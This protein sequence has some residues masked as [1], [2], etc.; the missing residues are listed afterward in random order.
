MNI[1][2]FSEQSPEQMATQIAMRMID[3]VEGR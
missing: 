1:F 2:E 3:S